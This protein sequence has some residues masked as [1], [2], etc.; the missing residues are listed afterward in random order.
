MNYFNTYETRYVFDSIKDNND[1][2]Q[3]NSGNDSNQTNNH[4]ESNQTDNK[5][6]QTN[7][8]NN[9]NQ[10]GN[11]NDDST[12]LKHGTYDLPFNVWKKDE[13]KTSTMDKYVNKPGKLIVEN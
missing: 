4:N 1:G 10:T 5:Q 9:S 6:N 11:H 12:D 3:N 7:N 2:D 13:N 8:D